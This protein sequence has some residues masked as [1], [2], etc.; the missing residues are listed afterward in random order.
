VE[1]NARQAEIE[2]MTCA[3]RYYD[4][5]RIAGKQGQVKSSGKIPTKMTLQHWL[6]ASK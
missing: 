3:I 5:A 6:S 2:K 1:E 4:D